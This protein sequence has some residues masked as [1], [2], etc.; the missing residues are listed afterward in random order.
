MKQ[1]KLHVIK[2][3][4][5]YLRPHR[6]SFIIAIVLSI[7]SN[8]FVLVGPKLS[9]MAINEIEIGAGKINVQKIIFYAVIMVLLYV[10][11]AIMSYILIGV[12][13]NIGKKI[14]YQLR[15]DVFEHLL[16]LKINYYDTTKTGDILSRISYDIDTVNS[17]LS[18]DVVTICTSIITV[19]GS[20]FS[21][22]AISPRLVFVFVITVPMSI[23]M[24]KKMTQKTRP[25][26][27]ER[28][29]KLGELNGMTEEL[30][31]GQKTLKAYCQEEHTIETFKNKNEEAINAYYNADY[32]GSMIGP[33]VNFINNLSLTLISIFGAFMYL[34]GTISLGNISAFVLYSRKF[35]GPINETA[36]LVS[37]FQSA[38]AAGERI[39]NLLD[40]ETEEPDRI[41]A[42]TL[43]NVKGNVVLKN[44]SFGYSKEHMILK[45]LNLDV[46]SGQLIAIVGPTGAGKTTLINLLMRFYDAQEGSIYIDGTD[47][48]KTTR[49]SL[50]NSYAMVLQDVWLFEGSIY[51]N[52]VYGS[53]TATMEDAIQVAKAAGIHNYIK[54]LPEG[55]HTILKDSGINLSKGQRQLLTIARAMLLN[56]P[57]LI[58]DEATS[59]V[60]T[61]TELNIQ[62]AMRQ[63]MNGKTCFV[64]AHR[65]S[66]I[67]NADHILVVKE[68]NIIEEGKHQELIQKKGY[69][70]QLYYSQYE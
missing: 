55:Y 16:T 41:D 6:F 24:T 32:Y 67:Q 52:I 31:S 40:E 56:T 65:L 19:A 11:S 37:E 46:K 3:L 4:F 9:G 17:C 20:F 44:V 28:S 42:I 34:Y 58:L 29:K 38:L 54:Q 26:F 8:L 22:V 69:Y 62:K 53:E 59:N 2:R 21:M 39:F 30:I 64:I 10:I 13:L 45:N 25:L 68:G 36:N 61:R 57:M 35:S 23:I 27:R 50:R 18:S 70:Y 60:D 15:K 5:I 43:S 47:I 14:S 66:T 1:H 33:C 48:L 7:C 49:K 12:M 63:L 51:E